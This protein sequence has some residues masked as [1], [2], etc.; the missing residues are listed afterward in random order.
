MK[1]ADLIVN[2]ILIARIK[3]L[4]KKK[5]QKED[6][7]ELIYLIEKIS[8][9]DI[10]DFIV[11]LS[12][13]ADGARSE[14]EKTVTDITLQALL[15]K[16]ENRAYTEKQINQHFSIYLYKDKTVVYVKESITEKDLLSAIGMRI[17]EGTTTMRGSQN[18]KICFEY[19]NIKKNKLEEIISCII[20]KNLENLRI[21]I[22]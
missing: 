14:I 19:S 16:I 17:I 8:K 5:L 15:D 18:N 22:M 20:K 12:N 4:K 1:K 9:K 11:E 13:S 21:E 7:C 6:Y 2:Q 3:N 10:F